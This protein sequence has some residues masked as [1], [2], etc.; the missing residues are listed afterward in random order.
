MILVAIAAIFDDHSC[1]DEDCHQLLII[2]VDFAVTCVFV[3]WVVPSGSCLTCFEFQGSRPL[4]K[5]N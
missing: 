4:T 2:L 5:V 1:D 3:P